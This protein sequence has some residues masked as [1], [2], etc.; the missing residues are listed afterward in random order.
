MAVLA[1]VV[2]SGHQRHIMRI[3]L[4]RPGTTHWTVVESALYQA[5]RS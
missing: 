5:V 3:V 1:I 2:M 4:R